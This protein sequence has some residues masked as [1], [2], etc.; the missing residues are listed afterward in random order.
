VAIHPGEHIAEEL[1]ERNMSVADL[2]RAMG[3]DRGRVSRLVNGRT[4]VTGETAILLSRVLETSPEFWMR[5]QADYDLELCCQCR[6]PESS[7]LGHPPR[8]RPR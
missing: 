2:A 3:V 7:L 6:S 8:V 5:L 1:D 4:A